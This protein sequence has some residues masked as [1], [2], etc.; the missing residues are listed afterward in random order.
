MKLELVGFEEYLLEKEFP[1]NLIL[2]NRYASTC[3]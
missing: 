1:Q 3:F 2:E